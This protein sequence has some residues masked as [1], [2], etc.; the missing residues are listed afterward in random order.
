MDTENDERRKIKFANLIWRGKLFQ[1]LGGTVVTITID[2]YFKVGLHSS[3][4]VSTQWLVNVMS[5]SDHVTLFEMKKILK[6]NLEPVK[7]GQPWG[8]V[9]PCESVCQ[10]PGSSILQQLQPG[11]CWLTEAGKRANT[12]DLTWWDKSMNEKKENLDRLPVYRRV[13]KHRQTKQILTYSQFWVSSSPGLLLC[14]CGRKSTWIHRIYNKVLTT[15]PLYCWLNNYLLEIIRLTQMS[16]RT[17]DSGR[18]AG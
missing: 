14:H 10:K 16:I 5:E 9:G 7:G 11:H 3:V 13:K 6:S 1:I 15:E 2:G 8:D 17:I 12:K 4:P 18:H